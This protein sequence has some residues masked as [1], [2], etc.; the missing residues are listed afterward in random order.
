MSSYSLDFKKMLNST[1]FLYFTLF[2]VLIET[3][4]IWYFNSKIIKLSLISF[5]S[6]I[7]IITILI[8]Y[9]SFGF[10]TIIFLIL[11]IIMIGLLLSFEIFRWAEDTCY[12]NN[13]IEKRMT[14]MGFNKKSL[15][16]IAQFGII[17]WIWSWLNYNKKACNINLA[18]IYSILLL[19]IGYDIKMFI[20]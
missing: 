10:H 17:I 20:K 5:W 6:L 1:F 18:I 4:F 16:I 9:F 13:I 8:K 11:T 2:I 19:F 12:V 15:I 3:F 7:Y 14:D